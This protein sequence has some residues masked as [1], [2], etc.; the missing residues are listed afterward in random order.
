MRVLALCLTLAATGCGG[1]DGISVVAGAL[2]NTA[3]AACRAAGNCTD[4]C[5]NGARVE[6]SRAICVPDR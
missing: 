5:A 6:S 2:E 4:T 3:R 1:S